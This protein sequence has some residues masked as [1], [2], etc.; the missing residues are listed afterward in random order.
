[1]PTYTRRRSPRKPGRR[2]IFLLVGLLLVFSFG[3]GLVKIGRLM[4]RNHVEQQ[5]YDQVL[6]EKEQL[7]TEIERLNDD[8]LYIEEIARREYGMIREG[9][10]VFRLSLPDS[11][12]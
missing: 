8:P 11:A 4:Y 3:K 10:E 12:K 6:R 5:K 2:L 9:E 1:M 7:E